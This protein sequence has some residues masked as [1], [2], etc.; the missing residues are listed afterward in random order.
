MSE[1]FDHVLDYVDCY[2]HDALDP[3]AR[4]YVE[5]HCERCPVCKVALD[6]AHKR[7]AAFKALPP[8]EAS[9]TL[10]AATL[11]KIHAH[12]QEQERRARWPAPRWLV[13]AAAVLVV[14]GV[15]LYYFGLAPSPYDLRVFG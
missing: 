13:A 7:V 4:E 8:R 10:I 2:V 15:H 11:K 14:L 3:A 5:Q 9:D 12:T 6:E 1:R